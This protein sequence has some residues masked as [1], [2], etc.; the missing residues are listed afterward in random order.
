L[1]VDAGRV[2]ESR[3]WYA[4]AATAERS[5]GAGERCTGGYPP[6]PPCGDRC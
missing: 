6:P 2:V 1:D 4:D 3:R 5:S